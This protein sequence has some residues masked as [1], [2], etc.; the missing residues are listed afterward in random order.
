M[1]GNDIVDINEAKIASNWQRP[2]FVDKLFTTQEQ[3]LIQNASNPFLKVWCLWSMKEAAYKLYTQHFPSRF[4]NPKAFECFVYG[5]IGIVKFKEFQCYVSTKITSDYII[6][7]SRLDIK[8]MT[9][10][11]IKF[12]TKHVKNQSKIIRNAILNKSADVF[13]TSK[14]HLEIL[15]STYGVPSI[16][17]DIQNIPLSITHH[18]YYGAYAIS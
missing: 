15:T 8:P 4:Y 1:V 3:V 6:S 18:G 2:R 16:N 13:K 11:V 17:I 10:K 7:E 14:E 12:E 9:S 5:D